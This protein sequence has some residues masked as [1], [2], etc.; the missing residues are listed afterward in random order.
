MKD[1]SAVWYFHVVC[2][3]R[4]SNIGQDPNS[5]MLTVT[6]GL[7]INMASV[8][9]VETEEDFVVKCLLG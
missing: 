1:C 6:G 9:S 3:R 5:S 8:V 2:S 4:L 7:S